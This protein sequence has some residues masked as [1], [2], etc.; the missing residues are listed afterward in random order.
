MNEVRIKRVES[1][2]RDLV[3]QLILNGSV[4]DPRVDS[5]L[6]VTRVQAARD[7]AS[8]RVYVSA[9]GSEESLNTAVEALNHA[10][11]FIQ[12]SI[13]RQLRMRHTPRLFFKADTSIRDGFDVVRKI[14]GI[15][16][17]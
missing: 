2:I 16:R 15:H 3:S 8:A 1:L 13:G 10:A 9:F 5:M 7:L 6:T 14:E 17:E 11:G 12:G 4:K